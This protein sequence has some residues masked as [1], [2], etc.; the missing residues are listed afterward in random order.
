MSN[1]H[2]CSLQPYCQRDIGELNYITEIALLASHQVWQ[3]R[4]CFTSVSMA[5]HGTHAAKDRLSPDTRGP[6]STPNSNTDNT[7]TKSPL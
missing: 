1:I 6:L 5:F 7:G 2:V 4:N 3:I